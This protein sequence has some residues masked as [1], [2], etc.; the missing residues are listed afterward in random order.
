[1]TATVTAPSKGTAGVTR[2]T[3]DVSTELASEWLSKYQGKNR[4][5]AES[6]VLQY[7]A[8]MENGRWLYDGSPIRFSTEGKILDG[9]HRLTALSLCVPSITIP[10][11]VVRGLHPDTQL[12]MD[13]GG[14]RTAGQ[15]LALKGVADVNVTASLTKTYLDWT[16]GR[17]WRS[18]SRAA[19]TKAEAV[20]YA[21]TH[22]DLID[23]VLKGTDA[24]KVDAPTSVVAAFAM[25]TIQFA[26]NRT[27]VFLHLLASGAGLEEGDPILALDR[28]LRRIRRE[29]VKMSH[30]EYLAYIIR[31]WNAWVS[32]Q[33]LGK[34]QMRELTEESFP[35]LLRAPDF[36]S[37]E[38]V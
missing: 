13:Q 21:L 15:Q 33:K 11:D 16:R 37:V 29:R 6:R 9:Q 3:V 26:P 22:A 10:F 20:D 14:A 38:G 17:L 24:R 19:T 12:V 1:M 31:T 7:Q 8:D 35:L 2:E 32:E 28:R 36:A 5:I 30:R 18:T 27:K 4:R 23:A 34:L 25:A